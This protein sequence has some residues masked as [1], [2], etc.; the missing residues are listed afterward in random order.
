K[1]SCGGHLRE[2]SES[3]E[4]EAMRDDENFSHVSAWAYK[5][6]GATPELHKEPLAFENVELS[7]RSYK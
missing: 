5:G 3:E 4:G 7:Q 6:D 2:E 1:E